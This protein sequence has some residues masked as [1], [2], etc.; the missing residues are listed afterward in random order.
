MAEFNLSMVAAELGRRGGKKSKRPPE[1]LRRILLEIV[2][3]IGSDTNRDVLD[4][5]QKFYSPEMVILE[6]PQESCWWRY[7]IWA[8]PRQS[9]DPGKHY[10]P[11]SK[12]S[13][14]GWIYTAK[15]EPW[16]DKP[17]DDHYEYR[18]H[19]GKRNRK[20]TCRRIRE[21]MAKIRKA[22]T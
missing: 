20:T 19:C 8:D 13:L 4:Y 10:E 3:E 16:D 2:E 11:F 1:V 12:S 14:G 6:W 17:A 18:Y 21:T 9:V 7:E 22:R 5:W 15:P